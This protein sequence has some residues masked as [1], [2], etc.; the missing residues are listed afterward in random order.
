M[1]EHK[2]SQLL[3]MSG[4]ILCALNLATYFFSMKKPSQEALFTQ[5]TYLG[6]TAPIPGNPELVQVEILIKDSPDLAGVEVQSVTFDGQAIPLKPRDIFG[7][8]G[9]ASFQLRPGKY[10]LRWTVNRDKIIWPRT[11]SHE[12]EV[13]ID[14]RDLWIQ[15][16]IEGNHASIR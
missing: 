5:N 8:R 16:I 15:I 1:K 13:T 10:T 9:A 4:T 3:L 7:K 11:L 12:E 2:F 14:P 6:P